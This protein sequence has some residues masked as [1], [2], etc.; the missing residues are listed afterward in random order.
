MR[1]KPDF[2]K[3]KYFPGTRGNAF[4]VLLHIMDFIESLPLPV[5]AAA[6]F[7]I[8]VLPTWGRWP[9]TA[10][11][12]LFMLG[13]WALLAAL[14][15]LGKS[16]GPAKPPA[17]ALAILRVP[18]AL[19]PITFALSLQIAGTLLV[20]YS[21]WIEPH[22]LTIT[23][24][25]L[26]SPKLKPGQSIRILHLGDLHIE[27]ITNRE[28]ELL[29]LIPA[30]NADLILFSGDFLNLSYIHD[31]VAQAHAREIVSQWSAPLGVYAV[32]GSPAVDMEEVV[33]SPL[34]DGLPLRWLGD[35]KVTISHN[36]HEIDLVGLVCSHKPFVDGPKL[37]EVLGGRPSRFTILLYHTPDLALDAAEAGVD[38]QLSGH[39][40]GGQVRLPFF[41]ALITASLYGKQFEV[42]RRQVD[43]LTLY[44]TRGIGME[45]K[46]APRVR[47]LCPPEIILWEIDGA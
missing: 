17:L 14:P 38:L 5:F 39:T 1:P 29:K 12:W 47:F 40:H 3:V 44:V 19:L 7:A 30:L 35:E 37:V 22:R 8:A 2:T 32:S 21:F 6:L 24:Q 23:K 43:G 26:K 34:L 20:I 31:P 36:G 45:G 28:R 13:D 33:P 4:D 27:R 16:F 41:G 25:T 18:F 9:L 46:G 11:L 10:G 15:R 42:G